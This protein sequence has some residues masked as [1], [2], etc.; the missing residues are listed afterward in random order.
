MAAAAAATA[1]ADQQ[2]TVLQLL[3]LTRK[4][5]VVA[6]AGMTHRDAKPE[7]SI[8]LAA[9][10]AAD[11]AGRHPLCP[12]YKVSGPVEIEE[13]EISVE[14]LVFRL[15]G[16][17]PACHLRREEELLRHGRIVQRDDSDMGVY[18]P[19]LEPYAFTFDEVAVPSGLFA[20][21]D[22]T[23]R[24]RYIADGAPAPLAEFSMPIRLVKRR[25]ATP[26][27]SSASRQ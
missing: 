3:R 11:A 23:I 17:A 2:P 18:A 9:V 13:G 4:V 24:A 7:L 21:G 19:R 22:Y 1:A 25:A 10:C 14:T 27:A 16:S 26:A 15:S 12:E 20:R 8:D 6:D 5:V